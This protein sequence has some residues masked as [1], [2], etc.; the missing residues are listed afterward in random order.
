MQ[1]ERGNCMNKY[2]SLML[3]LGL[4]ACATGGTGPDERFKVSSTSRYVFATEKAVKS[5]QELTSMNTE[6]VICSTCPEHDDRSLARVSTITRG[7]TELTVYDLEDVTFTT[8]DEGFD[9]G[10]ESFKFV[11]DETDTNGTRGKIIGIDMDFASDDSFP[12]DTN[13]ILTRKKDTNVFSGFVNDPD[14]NTDPEKWKPANYTYKSMGQDLKL[15]YSD[16]GTLTIKRTD[17]DNKVMTPVFIGG[18]DTAKKINP[19]DIETNT[20]QIIEFS[21]TASGSVTAILDGQGSGKSI[22]LNDDDAHLILTVDKTNANS[23]VV[24][25]KM[26]AEFNNWYDVSYTENGTTKEIVLSG[27]QNSDTDYKMLTAEADGKVTITDTGVKSDIR[28]FGDNTNP[29][30]AVGIIQVRDCNGATC[31]NDY[32][33]QQE[34][35]MN[36]GFGVIKDNN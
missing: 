18:Y 10:E 22:T 30:E 11:V 16:F 36:L 25:S 2:V 21:G 31:N 5:N 7:G 14:S 33:L 3:V 12:S 17:V 9:P 27:F 29:S 15:R 35:R 26:T 34:V 1:K 8:A 28:Y 4:A 23:P 19:A 32:D 24:S 13:A 20:S 6:V